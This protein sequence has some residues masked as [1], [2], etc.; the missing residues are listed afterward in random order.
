[1]NGKLLASCTPN[2]ITQAVVELLA[3]ESLRKK[4]GVD[5][6]KTIANKFSWTV[7]AKK[8]SQA[9]ADAVND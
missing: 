9:Y 3:D 5:A 1:L 4:M 2:D 6:Q 8:Y 7:N